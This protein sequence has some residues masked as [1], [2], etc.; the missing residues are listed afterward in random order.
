MI[1]PLHKW[2]IFFLH[3]FRDFSCSVR[4]PYPSACWPC[5]FCSLLPVKVH[6]IEPPKAAECESGKM[7]ANFSLPLDCILIES[8]FSAAVLTILLPLFCSGLWGIFSADIF[9]GRGVWLNSWCIRWKANISSGIVWLALAG[10]I[11]GWRPL[12]KEQIL[13]CFCVNVVSSRIFALFED[14]KDKKIFLSSVQ[15]LFWQFY[16]RTCF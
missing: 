14:N 16:L 13:F 2:S 7:S 9:W 1:F 8:R 3:I 6:R 11:S 10:I 5:G 12:S 15:F 4:R